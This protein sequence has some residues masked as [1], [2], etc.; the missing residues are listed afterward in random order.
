ML[1]LRVWVG[2][3]ERSLFPGQKTHRVRRFPL[4]AQP[5]V[6]WQVLPANPL[7]RCSIHVCA[8]ESKCIDAG[9]GSDAGQLV[10]LIYWSQ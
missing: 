4:S 9:V 6:P 1:N 7:T 3:R 10:K 5:G 8:K 2:K